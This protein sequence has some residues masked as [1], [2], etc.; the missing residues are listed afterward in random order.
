MDARLR[1]EIAGANAMSAMGAF[2]KMREALGLPFLP[3][4][5]VYDFVKRASTSSTTTCTGAASSSWSARP[6]A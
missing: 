3:I 2:G 6:P 5:T 4:M 1:F